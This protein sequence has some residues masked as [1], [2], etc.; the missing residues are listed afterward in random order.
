[1]E[2]M[3]A[4]GQNHSAATR[5]QKLKDLASAYDSFTELRGNLEEGTKVI[6]NNFHLLKVVFCLNAGSACGAVVLHIG[7]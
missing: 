3:Q 4:A 7:L 1:M 2:F 6:N 5:E